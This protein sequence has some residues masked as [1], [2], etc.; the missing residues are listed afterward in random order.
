MN[1]LKFFEETTEGSGSGTY[2]DW[3]RNHYNEEEY[4]DVNY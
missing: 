4:K 3:Y 1:Q 2:E